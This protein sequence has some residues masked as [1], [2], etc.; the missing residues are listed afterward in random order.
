MTSH[1]SCPLK[2]L[3][4]LNAPIYSINTNF[5]HFS[6]FIIYALKIFTTMLIIK[7]ANKQELC[8]IEFDFVS[9]CLLKKLIN[10]AYICCYSV[11]GTAKYIV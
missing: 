6:Y 9:W 7:R 11:E 10:V 2:Q 1:T 3:N 5:L 4:Y 8:K